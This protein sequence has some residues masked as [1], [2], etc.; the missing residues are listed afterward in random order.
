M[1]TQSYNTVTPRVGKIKGKMLQAAVPVEV[2]SIVGENHKMDKNLGDNVIFGR[3]VPVGGNTG[4]NINKWDVDENDYRTQ[5]GVTPEAKTLSRQDI[6]VQ[7]Q[8]YACLYKYTDKTADMYE[9]K[10]PDGMKEQA[11]E[12]MGLVREKIRYGAMQGCANKFYQNGSTRSAVNTVVS[13]G[14]LRAV[15]RS[16]EDNRCKMITKVL[17]SSPNYNTTAVEAG[18]IVFCHTDV[19]QDIRD[20]P[21]FTPT[22][23]YGGKKLIHERELGAVEKFRFIT[24]PELSPIADS[25]GAVA[26]LTIKSTTGTSADIYPIVIMGKHA[27]GD[28]ALRGK[29]SFEHIHIPA[30]KKE[31]SDPLGQNGYIG[32]KFYANS[33]VQNDY[34][35]AVLEVA[36]KDL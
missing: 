8:Q 36:V 24:S 13:L 5:E 35:M 31:K 1:T 3:W 34:W 12:T 9:D 32:C 33:F 14:K 2:L 28:L 10:I 26:G 29:D 27:F 7:L 11:G 6:T 16:L 19:E 30:E 4:A 25:G 23:D 17:D 18:Y 20:L 15:T 22:K 21:G